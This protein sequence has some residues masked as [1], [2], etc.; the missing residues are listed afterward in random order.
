MAQFNDLIFNT[1]DGVFFNHYVSLAH[2]SF[3]ACLRQNLLSSE[4]DCE[5]VITQIPKTHEDLYLIGERN[6]RGGWEFF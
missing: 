6:I 2:L 3:D 4:D 1:L 5:T